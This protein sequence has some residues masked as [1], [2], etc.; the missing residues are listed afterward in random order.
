MGICESIRG[1]E[2]STLW[3]IGKIVA[4]GDRSTPGSIYVHQGA[5]ARLPGLVQP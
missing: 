2:N 5:V 4:T 1:V 3:F